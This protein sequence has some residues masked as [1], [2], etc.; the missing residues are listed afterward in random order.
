MKHISILIP[1]GHTSMV[2]IEGS[3]QIFSEVNSF[4]GRMGKPPLFKVQLVG[5]YPETSQ[6]NGL[7]TIAPHVL[8]G[9]GKKDG[10]DHYSGHS[11]WPATAYRST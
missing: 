10:S 6:R 1:Q 4:L 3:H 8:I 7:F 2:N 9:G 11:W 5:I